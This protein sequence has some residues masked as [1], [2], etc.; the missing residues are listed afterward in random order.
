MSHPAKLIEEPPLVVLPSLAVAIG[1]NEAIALQQLHFRGRDNA[2]GWWRATMRDLQRQFP[3]WSERTV[4]RTLKSLGDQKL[5]RVEQE[6]TDRTNRYCVDHQAL[7]KRVPAAGHGQSGRMEG[8]SLPADRPHGNG[9]SGRV[10][11]LSSKRNSNDKRG[12][13]PAPGKQTKYA[14]LERLQ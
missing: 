5:I 14:G 8:A 1:L 3:F 11:L 7:A 13:A 10:S 6:G 12:E 2:G 4:R 9:Q